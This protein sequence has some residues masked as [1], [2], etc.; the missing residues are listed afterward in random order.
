LAY[1]PPTGTRPGFTNFK[2]NI[3]FEA[4]KLANV[5][6]VL[7]G[8]LKAERKSAAEQSYRSLAAA[9]LTKWRFA[10]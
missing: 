8:I 2:Y 1:W 10:V 7:A 5:D 4:A 9:A 6:R 3:W